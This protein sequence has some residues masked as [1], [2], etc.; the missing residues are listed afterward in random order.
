MN[1]NNL[2]VKV[3]RS[4]G[5]EKGLSAMLKEMFH[6]LRQSRD[7]G[8][9][10]AVRDIK[11]TYRKS[12][13]GILWAFIT[14][15][16]TALVWIFL[17]GAGVVKV[18]DTPIPYPTYVFAG[19]M[20]WAIF[21][22]SLQAVML[23]TQ[24][25]KAVMSKVNFPKEGL[26]IAAFIKLLFNSAIKLALLVL[27]FLIMGV[28]PDWRIVMVPFILLALMFFGF[29]VGIFLT[30]IAMLYGDIGR[31]IPIVLQFLMF[32]TPVV[33]IIPAEGKLKTLM[34]I[35]PV[36]PMLVSVRN[37]MSG[38]DFYL[39]Q[40]FWIVLLFTLLI[41]LLGWIFYRL[42]SPIIIER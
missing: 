6:D 42:S 38:M 21:S 29:V 27:V 34:D 19:T 8:I 22:E 20:I 24:Q 4:S 37:Y 36:T 30:P 16:M 13:L 28:Y 35:N 12:L 10:F 14:P 32:L 25:A 41:S 31:A 11:A 15:L 3:Y 1:E 33:Y 5:F 2:E 39:P 9:N 23:Q 18:G 26:L 40:Y 17:N 7:L